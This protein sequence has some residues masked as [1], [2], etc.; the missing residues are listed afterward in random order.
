MVGI[1]FQLSK[2]ELQTLIHQIAYIATG[3]VTFFVLIGS[4]VPL[5]LARWWETSLFQPGQFG[6]EFY[7]ITITV[8]IAFLLLLATIGL[9]WHPHWLVDTYPL[10]LLPAMAAGLSLLHLLGSQHRSVVLLLILIYIGFF[11]LPYVI[12]PALALVGF[13]DSGFNFRQRYRLLK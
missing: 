4:L 2:I 1:F 3:V 5:L 12:V 9:Y 10:L 13:T 6:R 8:L 11:I 7:R